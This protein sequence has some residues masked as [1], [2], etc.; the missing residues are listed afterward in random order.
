MKVKF[1]LGFYIIILF[2]VFGGYRFI[3]FSLALPWL[4]AVIFHEMGHI[5]TAVFLGEKIKSMTLDV[6]G[7]RIYLGGSVVSYRNE[8]LIAAFG[9]AVNFIL[10]I[11]FLRML[12]NFSQLSFALGFLNLLPIDGFDG[13]RI[14]SSLSYALF[15]EGRAVGILHAISF[16]FVFLTWLFS[17]YMMLIHSSGFSL[18]LISVVMLLKTVQKRG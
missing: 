7:A 12:P 8:G 1:G 16:V 11:L 3:D 17:A 5:I 6:L 10:G 14:I 4:C 9:P 18:F 13:Y 2:L 15:G